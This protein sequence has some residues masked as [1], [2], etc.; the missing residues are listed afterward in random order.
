MG[1]I[2]KDGF[3]FVAYANSRLIRTIDDIPSL[4]NNLI[5]CGETKTHLQLSNYALLLAEHILKIG[6]LERSSV[7]DRCFSVIKRWKTG[8]AS[9]RDALE[10]AGKINDLARE[11]K[12]PVKIKALRAMGQVAA[13]PHVR[14]HPLIAS[15]YAVVTINL[16]YPGDFE[17][18]REERELQ[19]AFMDRV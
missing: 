15:E 13:T 1:K 6:G 8:Q 19:I 5:A 12:A 17:K 4:K 11:E 18:V 16:L 9:V 2:I 3:T 7:I 10:I 14:W